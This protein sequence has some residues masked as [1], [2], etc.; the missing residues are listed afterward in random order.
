MPCVCGVS[1]RTG[2]W[3][4]REILLNSEKY[5]V[6]GV[7]PPGFSYRFHDIDVWTPMAFSAEQLVDRG[8]HYL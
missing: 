2:T 8:S 7:M 4:A 3:L 5:L 1:E 6:A